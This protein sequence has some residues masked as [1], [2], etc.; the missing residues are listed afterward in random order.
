M[1]PTTAVGHRAEWWR[2]SSTCWVA[3]RKAA[4]LRWQTCLPF[5]ETTD[6]W[7]ELT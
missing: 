6:D 2:G 7:V 3:E 5:D 4:D 1:G